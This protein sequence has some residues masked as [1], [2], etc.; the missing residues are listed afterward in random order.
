LFC[1]LSLFC[2][3]EFPSDER[4]F[5]ELLAPS[6]FTSLPLLIEP[7]DDDFE[8]ESEPD[9]VLEGGGGENDSFDGVLCVPNSRV[10]SKT[11]PVEEPLMVSASI[12]TQENH[13]G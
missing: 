10:L 11:E 3:R 9:G 5:P 6:D 1:S 4:K 12:L 7:V 2:S 13:Q 8:E